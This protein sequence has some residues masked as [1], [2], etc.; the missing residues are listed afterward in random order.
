MQR[1]LKV[2]G[3]RLPTY[4]SGSRLKVGHHLPPEE[5]FLL[6]RDCQRA[7]GCQDRRLVGEDGQKNSLDHLL[8]PETYTSGLGEQRGRKDS[9]G[10]APRSSTSQHLIY[11]TLTSFCLH[12]N[13][14]S[15]RA[16]TL[17]FSFFLGPHPQQMEGPGLE[18]ESE[19][20]PWPVPQP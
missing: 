14:K 13:I 19:L 7:P 6:F 2:S 5:T 11:E 8:A 12:K 10:E 17:I 20:Q 9:V 1:F 18:T 15:M 16:E 3:T 4:P